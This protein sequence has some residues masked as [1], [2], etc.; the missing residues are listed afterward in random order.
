VPYGRVETR[1][2]TSAASNSL[3]T[4]ENRDW[5]NSYPFYM[6]SNSKTYPVASSGYDSNVFGKCP[7][8][9][10]AEILFLNSI[11][12]IVVDLIPA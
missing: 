8:R 2:S 4:T 9:I 6:F 12:S 10:S 1:V 11:C 5:L 3:R 7:V